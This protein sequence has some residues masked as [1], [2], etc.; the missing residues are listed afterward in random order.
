MARLITF[1]SSAILLSIACETV[2]GQAYC[3]LR[4]PTR[5]I[6]QIFPEA[7]SHRSIVRTVDKTA[8]A[9]TLEKLPVPIYFS[10]L[11]RHT[12]YVAMKGKTPLGY[13]HVRSERSDWGLMEVA[14]GLNLNLE[15]VDYRFQRCRSPLEEQF[16]SD[17]FRA[18]L[19][20][21]SLTTLGALLDAEGQLRPKLLRVPAKGSALAT[22]LI[23]CALKTIVVTETTW[24][25]DLD[26]LQRQAQAIGAF[27]SAAS[28]EAIPGEWSTEIE[29]EGV[30]SGFRVLDSKGNVL[31]WLAEWSSTSLGRVWWCLGESAEVRSVDCRGGWPDESTEQSFLTTS[32]AEECV[33]PARLILDEIIAWL[34]PE[35]AASR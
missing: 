2:E 22:K 19:Q 15:I 18:Q 14:W 1:L 17:A 24:A 21:K 4:D 10:E 34:E 9:A 23:H 31:G 7:T 27:P 13:V 3:A 29:I 28:I 12:L 11:G 32:T 16:E 25:R 6:H 26:E 33:G 5:Q 8:R 30:V 35:L 20:G